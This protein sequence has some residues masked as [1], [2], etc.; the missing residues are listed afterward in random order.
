MV[1]KL[2]ELLKFLVFNSRTKS[3]G[4]VPFSLFT[5]YCSLLYRFLYLLS[6]LLT[7]V[8]DI[9]MSVLQME[10]NN[11]PQFYVADDGRLCSMGQHCSGFPRVLYDAFI[12]LGYDGDSPVYRCRLSR[13][14]DLD[15]CEV[16]MMIPFDPAE[17]WSGSIICTLLSPPYARTASPLLRHCLLRFS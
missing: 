5:Y 16:S 1:R 3:F 7:W 15:M 6:E 12:R 17:P 13:V 14:H 4:A 2:V 11:Y 10:L 8:S 9:F